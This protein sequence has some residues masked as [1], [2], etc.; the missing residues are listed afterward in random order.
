MFESN[1]SLVE[2]VVRYILMM[3]T[4]IIGGIFQSIPLMILGVAF[5]M[6]AI[7]GWDPVYKMFGINHRV[8]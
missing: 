3:I 2:I 1:L 5:F 8:E 7:M 6:M 4:M